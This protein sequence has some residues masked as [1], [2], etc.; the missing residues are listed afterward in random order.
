M[1]QSFTKLKVQKAK[2]KN[3][4]LDDDVL[5]FITEAVL[6][7]FF[8][9]EELVLENLVPAL[10]ALEDEVTIVQDPLEVINL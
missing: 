7:Q 9:E 3:A 8:K 10:K 5:C 2:D 6:E 1:Q 4:A